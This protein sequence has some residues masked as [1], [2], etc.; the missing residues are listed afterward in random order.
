VNQR[1][2]EPHRAAQSEHARERVRLAT[3]TSNNA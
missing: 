3:S 2:L 1:L